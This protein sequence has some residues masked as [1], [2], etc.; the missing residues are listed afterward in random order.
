MSTHIE[1]V[2][3]SSQSIR[4]VAGPST[5]SSAPGAGSLDG[6]HPPILWDECVRERGTLHSI[7]H[8]LGGAHVAYIIF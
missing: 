3:A 2:E 5:L 1:C 4:Q 6:E 7:H 8:L